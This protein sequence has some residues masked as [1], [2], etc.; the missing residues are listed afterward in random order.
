[1]TVRFFT[2]LRLPVRVIWPRGWVIARPD[3]GG[4]CDDSMAWW[5]WDSTGNAVSPGEAGRLAIGW[6]GSS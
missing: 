6:K 2:E 1:M 4:T 5:L 3:P